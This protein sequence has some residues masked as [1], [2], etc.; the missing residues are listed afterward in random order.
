MKKSKL[1]F[2]TLFA[3]I[4]ATAATL[5]FSTCKSPEKDETSGITSPEETGYRDLYPDTWVATDA[6]GRHMPSY[7][8]AGPAK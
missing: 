4:A 7:E 1:P 5:T 2:L 6:L 8:E 3:M